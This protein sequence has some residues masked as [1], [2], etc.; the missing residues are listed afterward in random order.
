MKPRVRGR[1]RAQH[2]SGS[3]SSEAQ[4]ENAN[5]ACD[6][7]SKE[8]GN[9]EVGYKKPPKHT[10]FEPGQ[11]GNPKGRQKGTKNFKTELAEEL[12]ERI[13]VREGGKAREVSKQRALVKRLT[14]KALQGDVRAA[15]I[16]VNMVA[17]FLSQDEE[18]DG[19]QGLSVEDLAILQDF[20]IRPRHDPRVPH[21]TRPKAKDGT[22]D[23]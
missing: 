22:N 15:S 6:P 11:S 5:A 17:R 8:S 14:E 18:P 4:T 9:Y 10:R 23:R 2:G 3:P 16:I 7:S 19:E 1:H 13:L 12:Q 21:R 20:E